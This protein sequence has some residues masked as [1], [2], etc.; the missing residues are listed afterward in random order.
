ML[1]FCISLI[2]T[3]NHFPVDVIHSLELIGIVTILLSMDNYINRLKRNWEVFHWSTY[4][5]WTK[6]HWKYIEIPRAF[7]YDTEHHEVCYSKQVHLQWFYFPLVVWYLTCW[8]CLS[9]IPSSSGFRSCEGNN[10]FHAPALS[11]F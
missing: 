1:R 6:S 10:C 3:H 11:Y 9:Y 7:N 2:L 4:K 8:S 5:L